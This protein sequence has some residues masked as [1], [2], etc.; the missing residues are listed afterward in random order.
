MGTWIVL[1]GVTLI[2][3]LAV[4]SIYKD[5]KSGKACAGCSGCAGGCCISSHDQESDCR[6]GSILTE[7]K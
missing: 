4:R 6:P 2:V 3:V 5:K 1:A 7:R